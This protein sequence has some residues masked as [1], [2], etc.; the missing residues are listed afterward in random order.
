M[1]K[2]IAIFILF[3]S[4]FTTISAQKVS[5]R[6]IA[7]Q[8]N[9]MPTSLD[10]WQANPAV[11]QVML[12]NK[13]TESLTGIQF[14]S[15]IKG[16]RLGEVMRTD[17]KHP[18][19]PKLNLGPNETRT[20][21]LEELGNPRAVI[22]PSALKTKLLRDG[23]P[24]DEYTYCARIL[25]SRAVEIGSEQCTSL[26]VVVPDAPTLVAP[27]EGYVY[28]P[29]KMLRFS[30]TAV[31]GVGVEYQLIVKPILKG[32]SAT[33]AMLS[34]PT[35]FDNTLNAT[36]YVYTPA[37]PMLDYAG[38]IG[39]AWQISTF[40]DGKPYGRNGG[41]ST[42]GMIKDA[43]NKTD[44]PS[45][46]ATYCYCSNDAR[47]GEPNCMRYVK[48]PNGDCGQCCNGGKSSSLSMTWLQAHGLNTTLQIN[49]NFGNVTLDNAVL[50]PYRIAE[51]SD[52][53]IW[54]LNNSFTWPQTTPF[55]KANQ[56]NYGSQ[57]ATTASQTR[58]P[59]LKR[60]T[61]APVGCANDATETTS[62]G[63]V[64]KRNGGGGATTVCYCKCNDD[65][66]PDEPDC[67][68]Y[69]KCPS[70]DCAKCCGYTLEKGGKLTMTAAQEA[71][72]LENGTTDSKHG[73]IL[74]DNIPIEG[75]RI[76]MPQGTTISVQ[77]KR[78]RHMRTWEKILRKEGGVNMVFF[79]DQTVAFTTDTPDE[80]DGNSPKKG[81]V[82]VSLLSGVTQEGGDDL[83]VYKNINYVPTDKTFKVNE[84]KGEGLA[85]LVPQAGEIFEAA[86]GVRCTCRLSNGN[87][88]VCRY[89]CSTCC[90][91]DVIVLAPR[92]T[93]PKFTGTVLF[94]PTANPSVSQRNGGGGA[95]TVCYCKCND[96]Y[97]PE[98]PDCERYVKCP[99]G[100]CAKCCGYTLEKG[101]KL[102]MTAAQE[103]FM[104][105]NGKPDSKHGDILI[106]NIPIEGYRVTQ[107]SPTVIRVRRKPTAGG[108][109]K[110]NICNCVN[111][112][113][114]PYQVDCPSA[115]CVDCCKAQGG[116]TPAPTPEN[117]PN[118]EGAKK[119][120]TAKGETR[121]EPVIQNVQA[122]M[123]QIVVTAT[124]NFA[125]QTLQY[126]LNN[127][128]WQ[129]SNTFTTTS[130]NPYPIQNMTVYARYADGSCPVSY[131]SQGV[132]TVKDGADK[133]NVVLKS[134][135]SNKAKV[136]ET[137][138]KMLKLSVLEAQKL[139]D[140][141]SAQLKT[142]VTKEEA[143]TI[144][145]ALEAAGCEVEVK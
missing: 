45:K 81:R 23:I 120:V 141:P 87:W 25:D 106:D 14:S 97:D 57:T 66:D 24:E 54:I 112:E 28:D 108:G 73:D 49:P 142:G 5:I 3:L 27:A 78:A 48:C 121:L 86:A 93:S 118:T 140:T 119:C 102:T 103:A 126:S 138:Q 83:P 127:Q 68:R 6:I 10:A 89:A 92:I 33:A 117:P 109:A 95:T 135:G 72:M 122:S 74:I 53:T 96:D 22:Y 79:S 134:V 4:V 52:D 29:K 8:K 130:N 124:S 115:N 67:E 1:K 50:A 84:L 11:I 114:K 71:F 37:D 35:L 2:S 64:E 101:G 136:I 59:G 26:R 88:R 65:Y 15:N 60:M 43:A 132:M 77:R 125:S 55:A 82:V 19:V 123:L 76:A 113:G 58:R 105:E 111:A 17:D 36:T 129:P 94:T 31:P 61:A 40:A 110:S 104:L 85:R 98:E 107:P 41:K 137:L 99:S 139:I 91:E 100:D 70:G 44:P 7:P 131:F 51:V 75:Y 32:Q 63:D 90:V 69:V 133:V 47:K 16:E 144:K 13:T 12:T 38:A 9:K 18:S 21:L 80:I 46:V 145:S 30:W 34:N 62:A 128:T 39:F 20:F 42:V 116:G 143:A 56:A